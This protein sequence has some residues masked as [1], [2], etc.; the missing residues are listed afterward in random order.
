MVGVWCSLESGMA[1]GDRFP[2]WTAD[3]TGA[4]E[5]GVEGDADVEDVLPVIWRVLRKYPDVWAEVE[6]AIRQLLRE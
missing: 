3:A 4:G 5:R 2:Q 6:A 1:Q